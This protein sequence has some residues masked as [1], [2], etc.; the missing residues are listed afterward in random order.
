MQ[1]VILAAGQGT[2]LKPLTD[3]L[4]K[5]LLDVGGK[6]IIFRQINALWSLGIKDIIVVVGY[7]ADLVKEHI[8]KECPYAQIIF[9]T[10]EDYATTNNIHSLALAMPYI[11]SQYILLCGDV[12][13]HPDATK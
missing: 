13:F 10:N 9:V 12:V 11:L 1:A 5:C 3:D 6:T 8:A 7:K 4:P 2:R